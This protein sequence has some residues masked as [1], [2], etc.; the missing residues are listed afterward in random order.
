MT[1]LGWQ[2]IL[3]TD[4]SDVKR[5]QTNLKA[6]LS[7]K[8]T[9]KMYQLHKIAS[10]KF[11]SHHRCPLFL[12]ILVVNLT[13]IKVNEI[14]QGLYFTYSHNAYIYLWTTPNFYVLLGFLLHFA[15][16]GSFFYSQFLYLVSCGNHGEEHT[17]VLRLGRIDLS[18]S[19]VINI[20]HCRQ[21]LSA[22]QYFKCV[23]E[24]LSGCPLSFNSAF[25]YRAPNHNLLWCKVSNPMP[26]FTLC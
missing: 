4:F 13:L 8:M 3:R 16:H 5:K 18:K 10:D 6:L 9:V 11:K 2:W 15:T 23:K 1:R 26:E 24:E 14:I 12:S 7:S 21:D 19:Q 25:I 20:W 22:C 17:R